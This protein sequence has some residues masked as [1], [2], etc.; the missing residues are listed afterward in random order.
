M[1]SAKQHMKKY[2]LLI[3]MVFSTLS[4]A[5]FQDNVFEKEKVV[6][7]STTEVGATDQTQVARDDNGPPSN[8]G[9]DDPVPIDDYL[10]VL[11]L[12]GLSIIIYSQRKNKKVNI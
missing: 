12:S 10:L 6:A 9:E 8:P 5:Q 4:F 1:F 7:H 2:F 3:L 11:L